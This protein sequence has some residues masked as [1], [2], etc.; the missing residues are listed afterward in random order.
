YAPLR[1]R[2]HIYNKGRWTQGSK[3][4]T[5]KYEYYQLNSY[6]HKRFIARLFLECR[7]DI[8]NCSHKDDFF[9]MRKELKELKDL[10]VGHQD[11]I[12]FLDSNNT[13]VIPEQP[14]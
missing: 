2:P 13:K 12:S 14:Q 4:Y 1:P 8:R 6:Y 11:R 3:K 7:D 5:E 10:F 9:K